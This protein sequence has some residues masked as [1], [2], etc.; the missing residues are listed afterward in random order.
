MKIAVDDGFRRVNEVEVV[1]GDLVAYL[2]R[3]EVV[4]VAMVIEKCTD[5]AQGSFRFLV[6]SKLGKGPEYFHDRRRGAG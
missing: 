3:G 5:L 1:A 6:V 2:Q 4:H